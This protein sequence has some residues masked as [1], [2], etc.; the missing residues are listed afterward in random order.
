MPQV[1]IDLLDGDTAAE[2]EL[3]SPA[4]GTCAEEEVLG[5]LILLAWQPA[6][7]ELD[8][9]SAVSIALPV[10]ERE[11]R[12]L[13]GVALRWRWHVFEFERGRGS[14]A[15]VSFV[16]HLNFSMTDGG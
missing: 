3:D 5:W 4:I 16:C 11:L 8:Q 1:S 10:H 2:I 12:L 7:V 15:I 9:L 14:S 6:V 13:A